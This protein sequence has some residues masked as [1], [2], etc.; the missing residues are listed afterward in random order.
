MKFFNDAVIPAKAGIQKKK[1]GF[2]WP[3]LLKTIP[4]FHRYAA[5][6]SATRNSFLTNLSRLRG[7]D[8]RVVILLILCSFLAA[9]STTTPPLNQN[10]S[11][12]ARSQQ[13]ATITAFTIHGAVALR[14]GKQAQNASFYFT[15]QNASHYRLAL[16]GPLGVGRT[17]LIGTDNGVTLQ[18][19][20]GKV[21]SADSPEE[22]M[23]EQ[24][25]WSLPV[26]NLYYWV[27]GLPAPHTRH[28]QQFD[29]YHHVIEMQQQGW[30]IDYENYMQ[31][32]N[33]D[34]PAKIRW[35]RGKNLRAVLV[36]SSWK[37][38]DS[39]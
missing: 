1:F 18:M 34:L 20:N 11:W 8:V 25:G 35:Q 36:I 38:N 21:Y 4:G 9:C 15:A 13:L 12:H 31:V 5:R 7:N 33:F 6:K 19:S 22:L 37:V 26:S 17:T 14:D 32:G 24:L 27:R 29:A 39:Y 30:H 10:V 28:H 3:G 2:V 23:R 16:Y